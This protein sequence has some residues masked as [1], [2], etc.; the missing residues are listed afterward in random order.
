MAIQMTHQQQ[1]AVDSRGGE[2]L[3]SA[4]AGSGKTRILVDRLRNRMEEEQIDIDRFLVITYTKAAAAELRGRIAQSLNERISARPEDSFLRRQKYKLYRTQIS[5]IHSF[6]TALLREEGYRIDLSADFRVGD[7][8]DCEAIRQKTLARLLEERY[9]QP[10]IG[11]FS[12][13]LDTLSA[14]RDDKRLADIVLDIHTRIQSHPAP[15]RWLAQQASAFDLQQVGDIAD[16]PWGAL[17]LGNACREMEYWER[18]FVQALDLLHGDAALEKAYSESF[19]ETLDGMDAFLNAAQHGWDS[20]RA[21]SD[22]PF[23]RLSAARKVEDAGLKERVQNMRKKCQARMKQ[24]K[25]GFADSNAEL[26]ADMEAVRPVVEALLSLV[27]QFDQRYSME[28]RKRNLVDFADLEHLALRVLE[29]EEVAFRWREHFVEVMV[30]EYQ[31]TNEVQNAIFRAVSDGGHRLFQV[32]DVKQSIYRFRLADPTIFL[33]KYERFVPDEAAAAAQARKVILTYNF[34]SRASVLNG[35]NFV[36]DNI[37][38]RAFGEMDY[39]GE[40]RLVPKLPYPPQTLDKVE[41]NV[42]DMASLVQDEDEAKTGRDAAEAEF[43]ARRVRRLLDEGHPVTDGEGFRTV[44][45][46]DIAILYRSPGAVMGHLGRAL[47]RHRIPWSSDGAGAF[48]D[49]DEIATAISFLEI[50]DNPHQDAPLLAVLTCPVCHFTGDDLALLRAAHPKG[51]LFDCLLSGAERGEE[52]AARFLEQLNA[53]RRNAVDMEGHRLLWH[54]YESTGLLSVYASMDGGNTRLENLRLLHEYARR[55]EGNGHQG[56]FGLVAQL[57]RLRQNGQSLPGAAN[58]SGGG[59]HVMSVHKSKGLEYPVVLVA[60]LNRSF[61]RSDQRAPVLFHPTLGV[62]PQGLDRALRI[63]FPTI[64]RRAV[65]FKL[66]SEMK[67]EELRLLYVAMTRAREKLILV[68]TTHNWAKDGK[69]LADDAGE[70]PDPEALGALATVGK[71]LLL[72]VLAR[73]EAHAL[74]TA[75]DIHVPMVMTDDEWD[76]RLIGAKKPGATH[77]T[78]QR[79]N[80]QQKCLTDEDLQRLMW[81]NPHSAL[82]QTPSKATAT[83]LKGRILDAE[84]AEDTFVYEPNDT[85]ARARFDV[86]ERGLQANQIGTAVHTVMQLIRRECAADPIMVREEIA[87]LVALEILTRQRADAIR[88]E[89]IARFFASPLGQEAL[90]APDLK[91]EFKFSVLVRADRLDASLPP[92]EEIMLQGVIDCCF[93][94]RDGLTVVDFKTDRL[95]AGEELVH[96]ERYRTQLDIYTGALSRMT[97]VAVAKRVLW[98]FATGQGVEI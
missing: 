53:L 6:C 44:K 16:T 59:V 22:I 1:A 72:P 9:A 11:D 40:H 63:K 89:Q 66:D 50:V 49:T 45:P 95:H 51:D 96:S 98:Y 37:M 30:D 36:F 78:E 43:V 85:F 71:W 39:T 17:L 35:V 42:V 29:I 64:A 24:I 68:Y 56:V 76:I 2:L 47:N 38:S 90:A 25:A 8:S 86:A 55:F 57:R 19:S 65:E 60:G 46:E 5:T 31:D 69:S 33:E 70:K 77:R 54:I 94:G 82:A 20:A 18:R 87:R 23:P 88:P 79:I 73:P 61:N 28:K 34:R 52:K 81:Q 48:F 80:V 91:R 27:A 7:E 58:R 12:A 3:V 93:T 15:E 62:G 97:G 26:L 74:R 67:A 84:A 32:G 14:G 41:L 83:Q 13:L 4:A 21:V 10:V 92:E 75:A